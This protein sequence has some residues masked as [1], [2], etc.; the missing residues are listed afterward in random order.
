MNHQNQPTFWEAWRLIARREYVTRIR[1]KAFLL[2]TFLGPVL[3]VG[4]VASLVLLTQGTEEEVKV[5]VVDMDGLLTV[6]G[7]Q[8]AL[9]PWCPSCFPERRLL[10]YRFGQETKTK[11]A[12]EAEGFTCMILLDEG[13]VQS[14]KG[15]LLQVSPPSSSAK[16]SM[17]RD[18][19]QALERLKVREELEVDYEAYLALKTDV[20][21]VALDIDTKE[22]KGSEHGALGF[23]FSVFMFMFV[24][25]Y[26]MH[27]MRGVIEEKSNR[28]VEV[29]LSTVQ[30]VQL[31]LGKMAGIGALGL[32]QIATWSV[33]SWLLMLLLGLGLEQSEWLESWTK[34]QGMTAGTADFQTVL[35]AQEEL[36]FLLDINWAVMLGCAAIY[37]VLGYALYASFFAMIGSMVEQESDAQYLLLPVML[38][39]LFSYILASMSIE[40]PE[41]TLAVVSS[42]VPLSSPI[43]MMVRLPMGVPWWHVVVSM[44]LLVAATAVLV[45]LA[46]RVYRVTI[47]MTGK[48]PTFREVLR[49]M[50]NPSNV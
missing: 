14:E 24:M 44:I 35:A 30:P 39:L 5:Y 25:I 20:Q 15:Q 16:R 9:V 50:F 26:G 32:T 12:L 42:F 41:S 8:G 43:S 31:L 18:I 7:P 6:N 27:V 1:R 28:I 13:I 49:W 19:S 17:E 48:R 46:A 22:R 38:P 45:A 29:V 33:L 21:L 34:A 10:T 23:L 37:F 36:A 11:P 47:L 3:F 40:A 2:A 4:L